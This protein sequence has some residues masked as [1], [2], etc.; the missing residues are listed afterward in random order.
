MPGTRSGMTNLYVI[1]RTPETVWKRSNKSRLTGDHR[2][3]GSVD[4]I[5]CLEDHRNVR[6]DG[7]LGEVELCGNDFVGRALAQQR[8]YFDLPRSQRAIVSSFRP[9]AFAFRDLWYFVRNERGN[10]E[11]AIQDRPNCRKQHVLAGGFGDIAKGSATK[12][13]ANILW[14]LGRRENDDRQI[15]PLAPERRDR[16]KSVHSRHHEIKHNSVEIAV[17]INDG[18]SFIGIAGLQDGGIRTVVLEQSRQSASHNRMIVNYQ[19]LHRRTLPRPQHS[20]GQT[21]STLPEMLKV[22]V[23]SI[24]CH[25]LCFPVPHCDLDHDMHALFA[26]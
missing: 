11:T 13:S 19:Q 6:L 3:L 12:R 9:A 20:L 16:L 26:L 2:C 4:N 23:E 24:K 10:I 17:A 1:A 22:P 14:V 5:Q 8:E 15:R 25:L 7:F 21:G 18:E